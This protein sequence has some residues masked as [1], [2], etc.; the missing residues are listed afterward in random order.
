MR[1]PL[2]Q[3]SPQV[4]VSKPATMRRMVVFPHPEGPSREKNAPRGISS[5]TSATARCV[6]KSFDTRR[7]SSTV[8]GGMNP[9]FKLSG[10]CQLCS[11][12]LP[13]PQHPHPNASGADAFIAGDLFRRVALQAFLEQSAIALWAHIQDPA[14]LD[15]LFETH[16][17]GR[18]DSIQGKHGR[19]SESRAEKIAGNRV[20]PE[21]DHG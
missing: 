9:Q 19:S 15:L 11:D 13:N 16:G 17:V 4:G 7:N 21:A 12:A 8:S 5:E 14:H 18:I 20:D 3:T 6:A 2:S 10:D 1:W